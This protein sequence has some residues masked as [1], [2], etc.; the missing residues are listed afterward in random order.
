MG[1][2]FY[3]SALQAAGYKVCLLGSIPVDT[4]EPDGFAVFVGDLRSGGREA[5]LQ[6]LRRGGYPL[7]SRGCSERG[8]LFSASTIGRVRAALLV[9]E[10]VGYFFVRH[11]GYCRRVAVVTHC[12]D[13]EL[14]ALFE[15]HVS[16]L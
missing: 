2:G 11:V 10:T 6:F 1:D 9:S 12:Y 7:D 14:L 15:Q 8:A 13:R 3:R 4:R 5:S 16:G